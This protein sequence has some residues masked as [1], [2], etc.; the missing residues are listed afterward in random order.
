MKKALTL[1]VLIVT[2]SL[3]F[4]QGSVN[5]NNRSGLVQR[6]T[7]AYDSTLAPVPVGGGYVQL[8]AAPVGTALPGPLGVYEGSFGFLPGYSSL[9]GFLAANPGWAVA[10]TYPEW[11]VPLAPVPINSRAGIFNGPG[12]V[13]PNIGWGANADYVV[14]G[15]TGPY[16]SYDAAYAADLATPNSSFLGMSAIATTETCSMAY[17]NP[18]VP[19]S[20]WPTFQGMTLAPEV[21]P[22]P[23]TVLLAGLGAVLLLLFRRRG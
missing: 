10:Q 1:V 18:G 11:G 2:P 5:L 7:S 17:I 15:W 23:T 13:I 6:W 4:A 8:V 14:I 19:V 22:E 12:A 16:A 3:I 9:A 20:L 21:I